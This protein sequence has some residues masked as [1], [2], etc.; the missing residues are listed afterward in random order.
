[1]CVSFVRAIASARRGSNHHIRR[2][3]GGRGIVSGG[4][5]V[6]SFA[7]RR[8]RTSNAPPPLP[9]GASGATAAREKSSRASRC[10]RCIARM[11]C[12]SPPPLTQRDAN[13]SA[14]VT[15]QPIR[16]ATTWPDETAKARNIRRNATS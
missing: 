4:F 5:A 11:Y 8:T 2:V 16:S 12:A 1:M 14:S 13:G 3:A 9:R 7:A 6:G 10:E 15:H